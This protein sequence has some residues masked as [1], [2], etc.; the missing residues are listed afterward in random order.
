M[1]LCVFTSVDYLFYTY[2]QYAVVN[3]ASKQDGDMEHGSDSVSTSSYFCCCCF[4]IGTSCIIILFFKNN[5][6]L[7][8]LFSIHYYEI[9][10]LLFQ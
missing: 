6:I 5:I 1:R 3:A 7:T 9:N 2:I 4:V 8:E 10:E